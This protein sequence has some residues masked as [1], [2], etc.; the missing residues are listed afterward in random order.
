MSQNSM[1]RRGLLQ[2]TAAAALI[3]AMPARSH[4]QAAPKRGGMLRIGHSG[5]A[6][7]DSI[8]PATYAA[9]PV[10]TAMLGGVCN[11]LA[12][13][14]VDGKIVP[15]LAESM[16][17]SPDAKV[18]TFK[19]R[20]GVTFSNGKPLTPE[21]VIASFN[22]HRA[23]DSTSG[24]KAILS[25]VV[26][27]RKDGEAVVFE[28]KSG[29][30]DFPFLTAEYQFVIMPANSD[31]TLDWKSGIGTGGYTLESHEP[32]V[33]IKLKRR[34]DYWKPDHAW[35]DE[36]ELLTINDATARQNALLT[37]QVDVINSV[38]IKTLPLLQRKKGVTIEEVTGT[39]H[40]LWPM[41][42][43]SE[44][45]KDVNVRLALKYAVN[46]E[47][48]LQKILRGH[49]HLGNDSPIAPANRFYAADLPQRA[50]DPDKA[51]FHLKKAGHDTLKIELSAA[52]AAF[53][54]ALDAA[55]L[56]QASAAKCGID[57]NVKRE[58]DDGYW[59]NVWLKKPF[60]TGYW[61]G[62]PT[63]DSMFSLVYAKGAD[64][65]ESHWSNDRFNQ[66]LLEARSSLD[67]NKRREMYHE[68]QQ[69]VSDDGGAIIPMFSNYIDARNEK[70]AHGKLASNRFFDG[71]K[72]IDR[73]W[74]AA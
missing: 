73:W 45:F 61:N 72:L 62:R 16:E 37:D 44:P 5:G 13:V 9:G 51:K 19:L 66:L 63:E 28:L 74:S 22:H 58:P 30:A 17:P 6:T 69:L 20:K 64:W 38:E 46:R 25:E 7:S 57:I 27:I 68:M 29:N 12:E 23:K 53:A 3:S 8:D 39:A 24:A 31:G 56:F 10:V 11:N 71:W 15:E 36:V 42:C 48:L 70:V 47:E 14:D 21:D 34:P 67:E 2:A 1:T 18:W 43:D 60:V 33:R 40:Y 52:N 54:G 50:Y 55:T 32:G 26:D 41:W 4:A 59:S 35:F 49:G 65:N